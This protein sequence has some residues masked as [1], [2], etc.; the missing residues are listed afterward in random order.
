MAG[1]LKIDGDSLDYVP[2]YEFEVEFGLVFKVSFSS[3]SNLSSECEYEMIADG[4]NS[5]RM[6]FY[7]KPNR[8]MQTTVFRKGVTSDRRDTIL[9]WL[10]QGLMIDDILIFAKK[11]GVIKKIFYIEQGILKKISYSDLDA[12]GQ[13]ILIKSME[14]EHTG[15]ME[16]PV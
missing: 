16:I 8:K 7:Q 5:D 6:F 12:M 3:I 1:I 2:N 14:I 4:G 13:D 9:T 11:D 10:T 15:V